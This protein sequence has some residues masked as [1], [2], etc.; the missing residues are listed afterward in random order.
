M[1]TQLRVLTVS[2]H[3]VDH[4]LEFFF[5]G[6]LAQRSHDRAQL[7]GRDPP[8]AILVEE[9]EGFLELRNLLFRQSLSTL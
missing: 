9:G 6:V 7:L 4:V 2:V 1:I 3:L 5:R 8:I